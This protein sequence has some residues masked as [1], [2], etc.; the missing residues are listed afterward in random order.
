MH[1]S[2]LHKRGKSE[3]ENEC[4]RDAKNKHE[5]KIDCICRFE[6]MLVCSNY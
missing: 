2:V 1:S 6:Q 5:K 3:Q 4:A